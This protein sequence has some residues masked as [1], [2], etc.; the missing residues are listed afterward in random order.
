MFIKDLQPRQTDVS[1]EAEVTE[2]GQ[3]RDFNKMG[4]QGKVATAIIKDGTGK[5]KLSLWNEQTGKIKAG[6]KIKIEKGYVGEWQGELQLTTGKFGTIEIL[7]QDASM[8]SQ[9]ITEAMAA[10]PQKD[11]IS[12]NIPE[13]TPEHI[14]EQK[15]HESKHSNVT[16]S[17]EKTPDAPEPSELDVEEED[18]L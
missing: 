9:E 8:D 17:E 5:V 2:V 14:S 15:S 11:D 13:H 12:K 3:P 1:I 4:K 18:V 7:D 16:K 6:D 10:E